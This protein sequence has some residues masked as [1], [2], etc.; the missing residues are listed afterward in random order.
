M[1]PELPFWLLPPAE[2][3][4]FPSQSPRLC[5]G[6]GSGST[7]QPRAAGTSH[8]SPISTLLLW[9]AP[10]L[11]V[12]GGGTSAILRPALIISFALLQIIRTFRI[13][14]RKASKAVARRKVSVS[15]GNGE[16]GREGRKSA[17]QQEPFHLPALC[18]CPF[19]L[20]LPATPW[21]LLFLFPFLLVASVLYPVIS[22]GRAMR[23]APHCS[24][25][26]PQNWKKF[27]NS[28]FDAPGPNVA[29]TTVSDDVFMTFITSKEV[30]QVRW[31]LLDE[32]GAPQ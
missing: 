8:Q 14:T 24:P 21:S 29:T 4:L 15:C 10:N 26:S 32:G 13:E 7:R 2:P 25:F 30:G 22:W 28:E 19:L 12:S 3:P 18:F 11:D 16:G 17:L 9:A 23:V 6:A 1:C 5:P 31:K 20:N 27:G